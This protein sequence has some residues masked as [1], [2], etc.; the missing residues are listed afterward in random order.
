MNENYRLQ[1][2]FR[3]FTDRELQILS[4]LFKGESISRRDETFHVL[5]L[6]VEKIIK[7][8]KK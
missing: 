4:D 3:F 7:E 5:F 1:E 2:A 8:R 6:S